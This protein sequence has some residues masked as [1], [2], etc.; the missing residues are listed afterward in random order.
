MTMNVALGVLGGLLFGIGLAV[1]MEISIRR[2]HSKEDL[3]FELGVP[4]LAHLKKV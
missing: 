2:V 1:I 3:T 4:L